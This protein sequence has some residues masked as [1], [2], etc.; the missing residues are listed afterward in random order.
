MK[1]LLF[2]WVFFQGLSCLCQESFVIQNVTLFNGTEIVQNQSV[3]V[4]EGEI[5][6]VAQTINGSHTIIDGSGKFLMPALTNA[7]VHT[8][9][10]SQL[11]EAADAG[12]LNLLDMHGMEPMQKS[13]IDLRNDSISARL[14][15]AGYA[16]T[17][18]GGHG[19]QYGFPIPT[20]DKPED[21]EQWVTDRVAAGVDYIKIIV[22]PWKTTL[23]YETAKA[24]ISEAHKNNKIAVVHVSNEEDAFQV[25]RSGADGLVHIYSD[26]PFSDERLKELTSTKDFFVIPTILTNVLI[27]TAYF[28]KTEEEAAIIG[29]KLLREVKRLYDA[30]VPILAGT[31]PPNANINIGSDIY[32]E[33]A[34]FSKAGLPIEAVL[35]SATSL[36]ADEFNLGN[37]GY[38]KPGYKADLLL[39]Q[40]SPQEAIENISSIESIWKAGIQIK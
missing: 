29:D 22:E 36:P 1:S 34:Y 9:F 30:G 31:D 18:P 13:M 7:H 38:I 21:A 4:S 25:L 35:K 32:K 11:K 37:I 40:K 26:K 3:L 23:S 17:A 10:P 19:T 12:V 33:L 14:Y 5:K 24:I 20:L 28:G 27:Q 8:W 39:L 2:I 6:D 16:A 15:R